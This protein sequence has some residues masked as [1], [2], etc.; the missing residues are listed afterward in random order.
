M[1]PDHCSDL[2]CQS[3]LCEKLHICRFYITT[4]T[5]Q[6]GRSCWYGH[7]LDTTHNT[8][9][10]TQ[11]NAQGLTEDQ[12]RTL[13]KQKQSED[14]KF[15]P[16]CIFYNKGMKGENGCKKGTKCPALHICRFYIHQE[17]TFGPECKR[18]HS[19]CDDHNKNLLMEYGVDMTKCPDEVLK[20]IRAAN[21]HTTANASVEKDSSKAS[22][23]WAPI[24]TPKATGD[25]ASARNDDD[26][27]ICLYNICGECNYGDRC[28]NL[29]TNSPYQ[30]QYQLRGAWENFADGGNKEL[31]LN[32][33]NPAKETCI[34]DGMKLV[35]AK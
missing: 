31:E 10:L 33:C 34:I 32:Y 21:E 27:I 23:S 19:L 35:N 5:C 17:C 22:S 3:P 7:K 26:L 16:I 12:L 18:S 24:P 8:R 14:T 30:W 9:V 1:C 2:G 15:P 28:Q 29:H 6:F 13:L 4:N 11:R 20:E 25:G